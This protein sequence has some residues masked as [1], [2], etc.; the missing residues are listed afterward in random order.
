MK[1]L[2]ATF[3]A[4]AFMAA[5][6]AQRTIQLVVTTE[7]Y[8]ITIDQPKVFTEDSIPMVYASANINGDWNMP[9][10]FLV[11]IRTALEINSLAR[12]IGRDQQILMQVIETNGRAVLVSYGV[13]PRPMPI[14]CRPEPVITYP[15]MESNRKM[16]KKSQQKT[17]NNSPIPKW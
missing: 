10:G 1:H 12:M 5:A 9:F 17:Y 8:T 7:R 15:Q 6:T 2:G 13:Q 16:Y 3:I 11:G 4:I 14:I